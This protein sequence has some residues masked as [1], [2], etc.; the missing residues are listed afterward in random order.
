MRIALQ[1]AAFGASVMAL[2]VFGACSSGDGNGVA[3]DLDA[4][5]GTDGGVGTTDGPASGEGGD[6]AGSAGCD[7]LGKACVDVGGSVRLSVV[8]D[9]TSHP[10]V[11]YAA[12]DGLRVRRWTDTKWQP[13]G[14][15][16]ANRLLANGFQLHALGAKL[17]LVSLSADAM[18]R[19]IHIQE[20]SGTDWQDV[21]GS[22]FTVSVGSS[23]PEPLKFSSSSRAG[24][25]HIICAADGGIDPFHV[26][27]FDGTTLRDETVADGAPGSRATAPRIDIASDGA[28]AT[29]YGDANL[30]FSKN[31]AGSTDWIGGTA[32]L[33]ATSNEAVAYSLTT[34]GAVV[35]TVVSQGTSLVASLGNG[36]T[37]TALGANNGA[38][39]T[40]MGIGNPASVQNDAD[41]VIVVYPV[42]PSTSNILVRAKMWS[43]AAWTAVGDS[44]TTLA[45]TFAPATVAAALKV[46]I[47]GTV[48]SRRQDATSP[49][50]GYDE[51]QLP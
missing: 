40:A 27:S 16:I 13:L 4:S 42:S 2:V 30:Y 26:K 38:V 5:S 47:L 10:V 20:Y 24:K 44:P 32:A 21:A 39:D 17:F 15:P 43:G 31:V 34:A 11:A 41:H 50:I 25:I 8:F 36:T 28:L 49:Y 23:G 19:N 14:P 51:L 33:P 22:P 12:S 3:T 1:S 18:A 7:A 37:W 46:K 29:V 35:S 45:P 6:S 9:D 48:V